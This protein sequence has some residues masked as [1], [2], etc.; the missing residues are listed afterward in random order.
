MFGA[1]EIHPY[2]VVGAP[3]M[4]CAPIG[5]GRGCS[6]LRWPQGVSGCLQLL[7]GHEGL[8]SGRIPLSPPAC[9]FMLWPPLAL[10]ARPNDTTLCNGSVIKSPIHESDGTF[11]KRHWTESSHDRC[12][13]GESQGPGALP[14]NRIPDVQ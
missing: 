5:G 11:Q 3:G 2:H 1:G 4:I 14:R 9:G 10:G 6:A 8:G 7:W 12:H 13:R